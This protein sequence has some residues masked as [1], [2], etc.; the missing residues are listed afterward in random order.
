[1]I[2]SCLQCPATFEAEERLG[3]V[4]PPCGW[5]FASSADEYSYDRDVETTFLCSEACLDKQALEV[6]ARDAEHR[7]IVERQFREE[8]EKKRQ[9][10]LTRAERVREGRAKGNQILVC[11]KCNLEEDKGCPAQPGQE[12]F[13]TYVCDDCGRTKGYR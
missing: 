10:L 4:R 5:F 1:M 11:R 13:S 12:D 6:A 8:A 7:A 2:Y 3:F 9:A